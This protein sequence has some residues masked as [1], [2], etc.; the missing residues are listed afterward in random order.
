MLFKAGEPR[1][2]DFEDCGFGYYLY[3]L[4]IILSQWLWK[5]EMDWFQ[6]VF[7][8][9]YA[10]THTLPDE[11]LKH[12]DLFIALLNWAPSVFSLDQIRNSISPWVLNW[13]TPVTIGRNGSTY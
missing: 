5:S 11:Q 4:S 10:E 8:G 1:V 6:D 9:G 13:L 7:W 3:D 2:I 12:I